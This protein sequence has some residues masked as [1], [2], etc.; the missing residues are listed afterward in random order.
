MSM[1]LYFEV[2]GGGHVEFPFPT[3]TSLTYAVYRE[4]SKEKRLKLIRDYLDGYGD[5]E[6]AMEL[7]DHTKYLMDNPNLILTYM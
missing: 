7:F 6:Y 4:P 3:P 2:V 1:N 5:E